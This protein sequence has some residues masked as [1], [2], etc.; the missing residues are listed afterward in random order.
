ME[1]ETVYI[2]SEGRGTAA[3]SGSAP[4]STATGFRR[5]AKRSLRSLHSP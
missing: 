3:A 4:G 5:V 1:M 2:L